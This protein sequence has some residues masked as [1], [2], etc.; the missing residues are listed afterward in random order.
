VAFKDEQGQAFNDLHT[1]FQ[2]PFRSKM[3]SL[4]FESSLPRV[5]RHISFEK[6]VGV[7][8]TNQIQIHTI[9]EKTGLFGWSNSAPKSCPVHPANIEF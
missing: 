2:R 7:L 3:K 9:T 4:T 6:P 1:P 8:A 5:G